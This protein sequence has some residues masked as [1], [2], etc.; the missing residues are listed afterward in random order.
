M[1]PEYG[2]TVAIFPIDEMTL[3]YLRLTGRD[4]SQR[5]A[6]RGVRARRRDCS[7]TPASRMPMYSETIELDLGDGRAEPGRAEAPAGSRV[8][9][10]G[11]ERLPGGAAARCR[12]RAEEGARPVSAARDSGRDCDGVR[13]RSRR[14]GRRPRRSSA[15][16]SRRRRHRRDHELHEHVEPERDDRRGPGREEGRRAR[17]A[18]ASRG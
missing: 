4:E 13:W 12:R 3:D 15:A 6:R 5:A 8:A 9:E 16:R 2:A 14:G 18:G 17:A 7:A 1:C 10:E 11:E